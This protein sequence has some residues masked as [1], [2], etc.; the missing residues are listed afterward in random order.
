MYIR[1]QCIR[2]LLDYSVVFSCLNLIVNTLKVYTDLIQKLDDI[3]I[4]F[5]R[6]SWYYFTQNWNGY[7]PYYNNMTE[8]EEAYI[9]FIKADEDW[10]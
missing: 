1:E 2:W 10:K 4:E 3:E 7:I 5:N 6:S 8:N 9:N